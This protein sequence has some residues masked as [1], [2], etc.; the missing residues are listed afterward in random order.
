MEVEDM[1]YD[2]GGIGGTE[3]MSQV[4]RQRP[5]GGLEARSREG[6]PYTTVSPRPSITDV[7]R[8]MTPG[9]VF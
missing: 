7:S 6:I 1:C 2:S 3:G 9:Y 5:A 4:R 8:A